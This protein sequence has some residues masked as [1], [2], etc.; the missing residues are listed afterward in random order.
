[1]KYTL[2]ATNKSKVGQ[3]F[4]GYCA[5][6]KAGEIL[7]THGCNTVAWS[8]FLATLAIRAIEAGDDEEKLALRFRRVN[9]GNA[10][11]VRQAIDDLSIVVD[12]GKAQSVSSF[13][14]SEGIKAIDEEVDA[15]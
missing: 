5:Q 15:L 7:I 8:K 12:G 2:T 13:W 4:A 1:M 11:Q 6:G 9:A 3:S 10:S 14:K